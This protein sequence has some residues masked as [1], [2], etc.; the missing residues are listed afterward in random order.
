MDTFRENLFRNASIRQE[1]DKFHFFRQINITAS[2]VL[3]VNRSD[4]N[5]VSEH[6]LILY[7][8]CSLVIRINKP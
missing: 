2:C 7:S 3:L 4:H 6:Q 5:L 8:D 1:L